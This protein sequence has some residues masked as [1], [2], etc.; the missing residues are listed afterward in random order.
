MFKNQLK[1]YL[2]FTSIVCIL[3]GALFQ[4]SFQ[5]LLLQGVDDNI[6]MRTVVTRSLLSGQGYHFIPNY[7]L[8]FIFNVPNP[9]LYNTIL[10]LVKNAQVAGVYFIA[11]LLSSFVTYS[12]IRRQN[13]SPLASMFGAISYSFLPH[14][15]SLV[16]SGHALAI[17]AIP[18]TPAFLLCLSIILDGQT[19][20]I[21][22][23]ILASV[24]AGIFWAWMMIG[25]PQRGTYGTVLGMG[26]VLHLL[27]TQGDLKFLF[28][29]NQ[30]LNSS[31]I[32]LFKSKLVYLLAI[33]VIGLGIFFP[34]IKYWT[35][36]EF[37]ANE[38]SWEFA[39]SWSFPPS[40][41]IDSLAFG[42]HG[43]S[44]TEPEYP[45]IGDKPLSGNTDSLGFFLMVFMI[46]GVILNYKQKNK[47]LQFFTIAGFV[48]LLLSFGKYMPGTP[49]FWLW[50]HIPGMDTMRVPAKFLSITGLCWSVVAAYGLDSFI[51]VFASDNQKLKKNLLL[52]I[53]TTTVLAIL[54][55]G[56][57]IL[58]DGGDPA[59]IRRALDRPTRAL[60]DAALTG[61]INAVLGMALLFSLLTGLTFFIYKKPKFANPVFGLIILALTSYNVFQANRFYISRAYVDEN[62][63]YPKTELIEFLQKYLGLEYRASGS[64]FLP[65]VT[66]SPNP[67]GAV[68]EQGLY[69]LNNNDLTYSFP[70][71]D[72][73]MFGRIPVSRLDEGYINFFKSSFDSVG[74]Y[75]ENKDVWEMNKRLW[76]I[77]NV[78]YILVGKDTEQIFAN[79]LAQ[80]SI[81]ITNVK[82]SY[83][84]SV[85]I[86][87]LK[88]KL[89]RFALIH[90]Y[91]AVNEGAIY[92]TL[93]KSLK[94][95]EEFVLPIQDEGYG[96]EEPQT[97]QAPIPVVPTRLNYNSY[98][99]LVD[100]TNDTILYFG[101]LADAGW[102]ATING[103]ETPIHRANGIQQYI[104]LSSGAN[105][106]EFTYQRPVVGLLLSRLIIA[107]AILFTL[108]FVGY[109]I[110]TNL[111]NIRL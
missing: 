63:F 38:G 51:N 26:W 19:S 9:D 22:S 10:A 78:K 54:W 77:G 28:Q 111:K 56:L 100:S 76:Y 67:M 83:D 15:L 16:Y 69:G 11:L 88:N 97:I 71:Y 95:I 96:L 42:Y 62:A 7:W 12:L 105:E 13:I 2:F 44:S 33:V 86:Y 91:N 87:E 79:E 53:G 17:E 82:G 99:L 59:E 43:L 24:W 101:D 73:N 72:I 55:F 35:N 110:K 34:T 106:V 48:A 52:G 104:Y 25:E 21:S 66:G 93:S 109:S 37:L 40:E 30:Q 36:S 8:G 81:Y 58:T 5:G 89:P 46:I 92:S 60:I 6:S 102:K 32:T 64:L 20:K 68:I 45:Y 108:V 103:V 23:R 14:V 49:F 61:R 57:L 3:I 29:K 74:I 18:M 85:S 75:Q 94:N 98:H 50:Y 47:S 27:I 39:T 1:S 84:Q 31:F 70:Y 90:N 65:N 80:D 4:E 41:L 107:L